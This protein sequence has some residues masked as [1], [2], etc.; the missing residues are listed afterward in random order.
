M[1]VLGC[2]VTTLARALTPDSHAPTLCMV[3]WGIFFLLRWWQSGRWWLGAAAGFLLGYA[4][5]I[6]YSE[7][8]LLF[9]LYPLDQVLADTN[10]SH[11]HPHWWLL[12]KFLRVLPIGPLGIAVLL[13][14]RWK[15]L[16]SYAAAA[17]PI[18]AWAIP[19]TVLVLFNWF[20]MGHVTGYD[21][22]NESA[23]FS[24]QQFLGKWDFTIEQ[25]YVY[26]LFLLT[27]LGIAGLIMMYRS[28]WRI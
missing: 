14:L 1:I 20:A 23:G 8:L 6:R 21:A 19:V 4:L 17:V 16:R 15:R 25:V 18:V 27:P 13:S 3:V 10:L 28:H 12:I 24:T 11:A 9:P 7:A 5:T 2:G 22:T 26:G